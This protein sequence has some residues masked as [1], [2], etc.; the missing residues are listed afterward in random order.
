MKRFISISGSISFKRYTNESWSLCIEVIQN[1][2]VPL[3]MEIQ[4][5]D[6]N[7][8]DVVTIKSARTK[9]CID[10][11]I[12]EKDNESIIDYNESK[13]MVKIS[14]SEMGAIAA[15]ILQYY[16]DSYASVDHLDIETK[17]NGNLGD[18]ATFVIVANEFAQPMSGEEAKKILGIG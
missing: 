16:R 2:I 9:E 3:F 8:V 5:L 6:F 7:K 4:L 18:D 10:L 1:D 11:S 12:S 13:Y 14:R 17:H 15:F